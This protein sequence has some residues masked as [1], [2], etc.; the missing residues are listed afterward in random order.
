MKSALLILLPSL[1]AFTLGFS[2][3][4]HL[5]HGVK[6]L[7][8]LIAATAVLAILLRTLERPRAQPGPLPRQP[9]AVFLSH[10][11]PG[12]RGQAAR[13]SPAS[14]RRQ[15]L[16]RQ[17]RARSAAATPAKNPAGLHHPDR[18][19]LRATSRPGRTAPQPSLRFAVTAKHPLRHRRLF[20][21][22]R[23]FPTAPG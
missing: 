11:A 8:P 14:L 6:M 3:E 4:S 2:P 16:H 21:L 17:H 20:A 15:S 18:I 9:F 22:P 7:L 10:P 5:A 23:P 19:R 13:A 12:R 1:G